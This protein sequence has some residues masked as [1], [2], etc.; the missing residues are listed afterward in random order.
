MTQYI[1]GTNKSEQERLAKLNFLLNQRSLEKIVLEGWERCLDIGSGLG[2]FSRMLAHQVPDGEVVGIEKSEDQL[3][4]CRQMA[5]D[6]DE[7]EL[8]DFREGSAYSLPLHKGEKGSFDIVFIRFLLEH[9]DSPD[10]AVDQAF[11]ALKEGGRIYL[12]DDD[13]ANFR[14]SPEVPAFDLLW[15]AYC[16]VYEDAGNDPYI[17]RRFVSLLHEADFEKIEIDFIL[18][19]AARQQEDFSV[20]ASNLVD[21]ISQARTGIGQVLGITDVKF[22]EYL[23]DILEWSTRPDAALWYFANWAKGVK[24]LSGHS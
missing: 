6:D 1:H 16:Q 2:I 4:A 13:H 18:F 3:N 10:R 9:L 20:Y 22:D 24:P 7:T 23:G 14:I 21:I 12:I 5:A 19:G 15:P 11:R 17:G 8:V